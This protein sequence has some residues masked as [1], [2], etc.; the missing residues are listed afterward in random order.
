L[1]LANANERSGTGTHFNVLRLEAQLEEA[2]AEKALAEDNLVIAR[3][4][5][6]RVLGHEGTDARLLQ[7]EL[8]VPVQDAA[9]AKLTP[10]AEARE[11]LKAETEREAAVDAQSWSANAFWFPKVSLY[12]QTQFY[13]FGSFD[14]Q[15]LPNASF[16][17]AFALGLNLKWD[18]FDGGASFARRMEASHQVREAAERTHAVKQQMPVDFETW[19]RRFL[20][21]S[22]LYRARLR[23][24]EKSQESVRLAKLGLRAGTST[25]SEVLDAEL[26]LFRARA[27]V[28]RAQADA[29]EA[30]LR[31]RD[32]D[33]L[34]LANPDSLA[35]MNGWIST[36]NAV[37]A[38]C[39]A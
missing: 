36:V 11:D 35:R 16:Q 28:V 7:G 34:S 13:K 30:L 31:S 1:Q 3:L 21:N 24:I 12:A 38:H 6:A 2:R 8:P 18:L 26:D 4:N 5:L 10:D 32:R 29:A 39:A 33:A 22:A 9:V 37:A 19:K 20:Y 25:N 27:G 23:T 15:I 14:P 17:D